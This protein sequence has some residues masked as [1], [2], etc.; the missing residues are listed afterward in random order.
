MKKIF[1]LLCLQLIL[2]TFSIQTFA[3]GAI[4]QNTK[5]NT[6]T[7]SWN[8]AKNEYA[9]NAATRDCKTDC[10]VLAF[11]KDSCVAVATNAAG[12]AG[13]AS[14][15]STLI[16]AKNKALENCKS[17]AADSG[18]CSIY[19]YGCDGKKY[20]FIEAEEKEKEKKRI[21]SQ[22]KTECAMQP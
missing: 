20:F 21:A 12:A 17:Y 10:K 8:Y 13:W 19:L 1:A 7:I 16:E 3:N 5:N 4:A 14:A 15:Q 22:S 2:I 11:Y 18:A 9:Q 6:Y